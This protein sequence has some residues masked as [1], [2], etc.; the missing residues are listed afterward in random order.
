MV[1]IHAESKSEVVAYY[2]QKY[3]GK[4]ERG[5]LAWKQHLIADLQAQNPNL[6]A[7]SLAK[8]FEPSRINTLEKKNASQY[9]ALGQTLEPIRKEPPPGG[10]TVSFDGLVLISDW[11][12]INF[13]VQ[14]GPDKMTYT[15]NIK[16]KTGFRTKTYDRDASAFWQNPTIQPILNTYFMGQSIASDA[17]GDIDVQE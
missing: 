1:G 3:P 12:P 6:K 10:I 17:I 15:Y 5:G 11:I 2:Q 8:R 14:V 13:T 16:T 4:G 7:K 9:A